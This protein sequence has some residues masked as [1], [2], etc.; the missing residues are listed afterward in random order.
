MVQC[1]APTPRTEGFDATPKMQRFCHNSDHLRRVVILEGLG[2]GTPQVFEQLEIVWACRFFH[3]STREDSEFSDGDGRRRGNLCGER[4][5]VHAEMGTQGADG[6]NG[7]EVGGN[8]ARQ[9]KS[10]LN[11]ESSSIPS[12]SFS[13][14]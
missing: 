1:S 12:I 3:N 13:G 4:E 7:K 11:E 5:S 2:D 10:K 8:L 6:A 14:K 9:G